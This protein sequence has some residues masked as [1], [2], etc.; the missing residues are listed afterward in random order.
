[1]FLNL[2]ICVLGCFSAGAKSAVD[3]IRNG[4][5]LA[6]R[7]EARNASQ[8]S[9]CRR[10]L[11]GQWNSASTQKRSC[12]YS[13]PPRPGM[14]EPPDSSGARVSRGAPDPQVQPTP[15]IDGSKFSCASGTK[16]ARSTDEKRPVT[17]SDGANSASRNGPSLDPASISR[18]SKT[19]WYRV[20]SVSNIYYYYNKQ[21]KELCL[22]LP[23]SVR[24]LLETPNSPQSSESQPPSELK[25]YREKSHCNSL[26]DSKLLFPATTQKASLRIRQ[27]PDSTASDPPPIPSISL[28]EASNYMRQEEANR[29]YGSVRQNEKRATDESIIDE[30]LA[31][32]LLAP[33]S[34]VACPDNNQASINENIQRSARRLIDK[35]YPQLVIDRSQA[36]YARLLDRF[37]SGSSL[38]YRE[39]QALRTNLYIRAMALIEMSMWEKATECANYALQLDKSSP[40]GYFLLG[41]IARGNCK[42]R[43][44]LKHCQDALE[45]DINYLPAYILQA[46]VL[47]ET[48]ALDNALSTIDSGLTLSPH[49]PEAL[50]VKASIMIELNQVLEAADILVDLIRKYPD[51]PEPYIY[52]AVILLQ[53]EQHEDAL[54][55]VSR[56]L[57]LNQNHRLGWIVYA[58]IM[59][60]Q[61]RYKDAEA[62]FDLAL[63]IH[64]S[65]LLALVGQSTACFHTKNY[66]KGVKMATR[67][68]QINPMSFDA[69][70]NKGRCELELRQ[71]NLAIQSF[72]RCLDLDPNYQNARLYLS[73]CYQGLGRTNECINQLDKILQVDPSHTKALINKGFALQTLRRHS[74]SLKCFDDAIKSDPKDE[75]A[76]MGRVSVLYAMGRP[77]EAN[78][79]YS[80]F[81]NDQN[82]KGYESVM[83]LAGSSYSKSFEPSGSSDQE[84]TQRMTDLASQFDKLTQGGSS[85]GSAQHSSAQDAVSGI[86]HDMDSFVNLFKKMGVSFDSEGNP[87]LPKK[88]DPSLISEYVRKVGEAQQGIKKIENVEQNS[89]EAEFLAEELNLKMEDINAFYKSHENSKQ[90]SVQIRAQIEDWLAQ[91]EEVA[92]KGVQQEPKKAQT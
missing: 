36:V 16:K 74:E 50:V 51:Y 10:T 79:F 15:R 13:V 42:M 81:K 28:E 80:T 7:P 2:H 57:C 84:F 40:V 32:P 91:F 41:C 83:K 64:P 33:A 48:G 70:Y 38:N 44:A 56:A 69:W 49:D 92:G 72:E 90:E 61:N 17:A 73:N 27:P 12:T 65:F 87:N 59:I 11:R 43:E 78:D 68:A 4:L 85:F 30:I 53:V 60:S 82:A 6:K 89:P 77:D 31:S 76:K 37:T 23:E 63:E 75:E 34:R 20:K 14:S 29:S 52:Q 5:R 45:A 47:L 55:A 67:A 18:I 58:E 88:I 86:Q 24:K 66:A 22:R 21:T 54:N 35:G 9:L 39:R 25:F 26:I 71:W 1:M 62:A 46:K 8:L 19:S 3:P